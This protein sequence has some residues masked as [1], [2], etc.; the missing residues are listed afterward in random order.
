MGFSIGYVVLSVLVLWVL[1]PYIEITH[2]AQT[3]LAKTFQPP[4][5]NGSAFDFIVVGAGSAGATLA[6]RLAEDGQHSV[7]LLEA[8]GP[9]HW[10]LGVPFFLP[11]FLVMQD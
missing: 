10:M 9:S 8:G 5:I 6:A 4:P 2:W 7:L 1:L 3:L 11:A